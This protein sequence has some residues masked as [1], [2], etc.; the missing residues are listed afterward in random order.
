MKR[1]VW[2]GE[3][4]HKS[5]WRGKSRRAFLV[6]WAGW[7]GS[8]ARQKMRETCT[9]MRENALSVLKSARNGRLFA[10]FCRILQL[11]AGFF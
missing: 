8:K 5:A 2:R 9:K 7:R 3:N 11:F 6:K 10:E 1:A 4:R